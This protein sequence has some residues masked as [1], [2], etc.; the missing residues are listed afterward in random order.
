MSVN[1]QNGTPI[2]PYGG[3]LVDLVVTGEEREEL[4][5]RSSKLPSIQISARSLCD[6]ELLATGAFS[7]LDRF[8][9]H[10]DYERVLTEMRLKNGLLFPIPVTLPLD[11]NALPKW[12]EA[13][14]LSDARNNTLAVMQIEDIFHYDPM[15]ECRLVLGTNDPKHPMVSEMV[16]W[17][18]VYVTG[19]IKSHQPADVL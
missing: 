7:P 2:S 5:A 18:K 14:T 1:K 16:R 6:L 11:E 19:E 13:I 8:M 10:S 4:V 17:G 9:S 12:G 15:R 3:K